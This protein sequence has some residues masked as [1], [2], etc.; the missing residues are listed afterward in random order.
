MTIEGVERSHIL[1]VLENTGWK[2]S[3]RNGAAEVLGLKE[4]TLRARM[5]KLGIQRKK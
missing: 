3:G 4:S 5:K 2:I 1:E